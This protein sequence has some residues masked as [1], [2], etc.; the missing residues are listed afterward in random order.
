LAEICRTLKSKD[1]IQIAIDGMEKPQISDLDALL[2]EQ[3]EPTPIR[4]GFLREVKNKVQQR[5]QKM[6]SHNHQVK[7]GVQLQPN[8]HL[9]R[10]RRPKLSQYQR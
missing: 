9:L 10:Q 2:I 8:D 6:Q 7:Q 4:N 1:P 3:S 5:I